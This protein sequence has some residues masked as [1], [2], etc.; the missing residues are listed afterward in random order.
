LMTRLRSTNNQ[1]ERYS[2]AHQYL[3]EFNSKEMREIFG[4]I[5]QGIK[6][7]RLD[8]IY[9]FALGERDI[10]RY[11]P[12]EYIC[13]KFKSW[14]ELDSAFLV[15]QGRSLFREGDGKATKEWITKLGGNVT[16]PRIKQVLKRCSAENLPTPKDILDLRFKLEELIRN[17]RAT[18][19]N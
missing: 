16:T 9:P 2:I 5:Q 6:A 11:L 17:T 10:L 4:L 13:P 1:S 7:D 18:N 8:R 15:S 14:G 12:L 3:N 19:N